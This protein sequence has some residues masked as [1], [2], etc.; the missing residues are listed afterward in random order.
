MDSETSWITKRRRAHIIRTSGSR[1]L[2]SVPPTVD[3]LANEIQ[4]LPR[5]HV[6][7]SMRQSYIARNKEP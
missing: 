3:R 7:L 1:K 4:S 5:V 2:I 6:A